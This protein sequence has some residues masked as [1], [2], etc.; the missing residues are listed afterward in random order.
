M[1]N[2]DTPLF[3]SA[4]GLCCAVGYHLEA[5]CCAITANMDHFSES[6]FFDE[7]SKPLRVA[8]IPSDL[9]GAA[10]MQ[11]WLVHALRDCAR[12]HPAPG[13]LFDAT[14]T[15]VVVLCQEAERSH[16]DARVL[17]ET[18]HD[19]IEILADEYSA[20]G[21]NTL[22]MM[23]FGRA[24]L[25]LALDKAQQF[26]QQGYAQVLFIGMDS[27]LN[28]A[29]INYFLHEERLL[30]LQNSNGFIPGE[31]VAAL[32][33]H[34]NPAHASGLQLLGAASAQ[35]AGRPDGSVPSRAQG[36]SQ[37][38]RA[39]CSAAQATPQAL[40]FRL[41][42]QNGEQF[43]GREASHAFTRLRFGANKLPML[44]MADKIGEVGA[45][46]GVAMLAFLFVVMRRRDLSPGNLGI[47]H[48]A[49]DNGLRSAVVIT[50]YGE[51]SDGNPRLR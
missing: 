10:R 27:Y 29:D 37:A 38:I 3:V 7:E 1:I 40:Q 51:I 30:T 44:S 50:P 23:P 14:Q 15:A 4:A 20:G 13:F 48:L 26:L 16:T 45:A 21:E 5:A 46:T 2:L 18:V 34:T 47:V 35:E 31:A 22:C 9:Q 24:G 42:D 28:A 25:A 6:H 41:S 43:F 32:V 19:A 11:A 33:L 39:A 36:L 12:K 49:N 17:A 8:S